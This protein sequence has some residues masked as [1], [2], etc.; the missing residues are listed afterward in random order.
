MDGGLAVLGSDLHRRVLP[1][2]RRAADEQRQSDLP[3]LHLLRDK[4]H[5][6]ERGRDEAAQADDIGPLIDG[7]LQNAIARHHHAEVD[8]LVAVAPEDDADDV[9]ADVVDVALHGRQHDLALGRGVPPAQQPFLLHE[10]LEVGDRAL[11]RAGALHDLRQEHLAGAEELADDLHA[12][13]QRPLD[14]VER[15]RIL[16]PRLL[17]VHFDEVDQS[18][19][20]GVRQPRLDRFGAPGQL[21]FLPLRA[22]LGRR[23]GLDQPLGGVGPTV[24]QHVFDPLEQILGDI[25]VDDQLTG[26]DDAHVEAGFDR[27]EEKRRVHRFTDGVVAAK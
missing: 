2:G 16:L 24:E 10:R 21:L 14:D 26:I 5:L 7:R 12:V 6:V 3:P 1:A 11:H 22:A 9:L 20:Q 4:H 18:V 23:R 17:G 13:H 25:L 8:D 19:H 27:V 15:T